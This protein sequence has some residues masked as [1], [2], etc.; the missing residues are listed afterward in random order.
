MLQ[1][2]Q[3]VSA[4]LLQQDEFLELTLF[5]FDDLSV[6][7]RGDQLLA[8]QVLQRQFGWHYQHYPV[9]V[10]VHRAKDVAKVVH[11]LEQSCNDNDIWL[12]CL[13]L[14]LCCHG[15]GRVYLAA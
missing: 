3:R 15:L 4:F 11:F 13:D 1:P 12:L 7:A 9:L 8:F 2:D 14:Q 10:L 6:A 5:D